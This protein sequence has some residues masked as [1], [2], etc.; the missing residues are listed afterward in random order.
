VRLARTSTIE[1]GS[2]VGQPWS[3]QATTLPDRPPSPAAASAD[4]TDATSSRVMALFASPA[5]DRQTL[6][7][8]EMR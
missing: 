4:Y 8:R 7:Q 6:G 5:L 1:R 2:E 3:L